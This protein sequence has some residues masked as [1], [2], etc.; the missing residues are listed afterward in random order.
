MPNKHTHYDST[1]FNTLRNSAIPAAIMASENARFDSADE[2]SVFF[3][4]ELDH[5][6]ARVYLR[7]RLI[8][9]KWRK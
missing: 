1:E 9:A 6:K 5:V 3:A 2:A 4:R 7:S 8:C